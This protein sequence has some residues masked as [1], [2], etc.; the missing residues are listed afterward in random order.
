MKTVI[1]ELNLNNMPY[2]DVIC[3]ATDHVIFKFKQIMLDIQR[4]AETIRSNFSIDIERVSYD[5]CRSIKEL[6][7]N[8]Y[9]SRLRC[10][11]AESYKTT[12]RNIL[13]NIDDSIHIAKQLVGTIVNRVRLDFEHILSIITHLYTYMETHDFDDTV[14]KSLHDASAMV[15]HIFWNFEAYVALLKLVSNIYEPAN[16]IIEFAHSVIS[17]RTVVFMFSVICDDKYNFTKIHMDIRDDIYSSTM[18]IKDIIIQ[19]YQSPEHIIP[20]FEYYH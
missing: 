15:T 10:V 18:S 5:P 4:E 19:R 17:L 3:S 9:M 14:R 13:S 11:Y 1:F 7:V 20:K 8:K 2:I 6:D 12:V 16:C